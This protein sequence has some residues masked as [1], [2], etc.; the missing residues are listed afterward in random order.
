V[1]KY[2][3]VLVVLLTVKTTSFLLFKWIIQTNQGE[4][5]L[6][7]WSVE[8]HPAIKSTIFAN[9]RANFNP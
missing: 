6:K 4:I 5:L 7:R 1:S 3:Q 2:E 8:L 9:A